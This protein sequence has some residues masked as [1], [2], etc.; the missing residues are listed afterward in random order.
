MEAPMPEG[1]RHSYERMR[2][3]L[4]LVE[5]DPPSSEDLRSGN[6]E[7]DAVLELLV[8]TMYVDRKV[9]ER[10]LDAI[11]RMGD[12]HGWSTESTSFGQ[13]LGQA[14]SRVRDA[15]EREGG[16]EALL[17]SASDRITAAE[18]RSEIV[19]ACRS[20]ARADGITD[21]AESAWLAQ[22]TKAFRR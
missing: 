9:T 15:L 10:E 4:G 20:I 14:T 22:V 19:G 5:L 11:E 13:A 16:V 1:F 18:V 8:A 12:E 21:Q 7:H 17:A 3:F 2:T 6:D